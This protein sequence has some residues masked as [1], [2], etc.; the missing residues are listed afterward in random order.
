MRTSDFD[1]KKFHPCQDGLEYFESKDTLE[2]AWN[3][4]QSSDWLMWIAEQLGVSKE[5]LD[6]SREVNEIELKRAI[7]KPAV[8]ERISA[9]TECATIYAGG[10]TTS[11]VFDMATQKTFVYE[12]HHEQIH[13][14]YGGKQT[15]CSRSGL[16]REGWIPRRPN[17]LFLNVARADCREQLVS[18]LDDLFVYLKYFRF[19][20]ETEWEYIVSDGKRVAIVDEKDLLKTLNDFDSAFEKSFSFDMKYYVPDADLN[21]I[22][23]VINVTCAAGFKGINAARFVDIREARELTRSVYNKIDTLFNCRDF[24]GQQYY[25][26]KKIGEKYYWLD[27]NGLYTEVYDSVG[28]FYEKRIGGGFF[29]KEEKPTM[30]YEFAE[31]DISSICAFI[32]QKK[33]V[34]V[35]TCK[36]IKFFAEIEDIYE[37]LLL[38]ASSEE[39]EPE[40]EQEQ[41]VRAHR[42]RKIKNKKLNDRE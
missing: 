30:F 4:C 22:E 10:G 3:D 1:I 31:N 37:R 11:V 34:F 26:L 19:N 35:E 32:Y 29:K 39:P 7:L 2:D 14:M 42:M 25:S 21:T 8:F 40:Q 38:K 33:N 17:L 9:G 18:R 36:I 15:Y 5:I 16:S 27:K 41:E 24:I 23:H 6:K 13:E 28:Q 20:E 12:L